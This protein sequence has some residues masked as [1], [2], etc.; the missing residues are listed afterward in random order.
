M[1]RTTGSVPGPVTITRALREFVA[2]EVAGGIVLVA[3]AVCGLAWVNGPWGSTYERVW[4]TTFSLSL[5]RWTL[6]L[7]L[8]EWV[9]EGLMALFF[10]VVALEIKRELVEGELRDPRRAALPVIGAVGGMVVPALLYLVISGGGDPARG[11]GIPMA[12]DIAF[13]LGVLALVGRGLPSTL[14]LF[15]LTLAIVDDIGAILVIALFYSGGIAVGWLTAAVGVYAVAALVRARGIVFT[16]IFVGF[17]LVLWLLVHASGLHATLAG[18]AMGLLAPARPTLD[19]PIVVSRAEQML[20]VFSPEAARSTSRL[21]QLAVSQLEWLL[22]GLHPWTTLVIVPIFALANSGVPLSA[23]SLS[24]ALSSRV[25]LA[26]LVGLVVGKTVGI[27]AASWLGCRLGVAT[28]P[29]GVRWPQLFGIAM[30]GGIGFTV[31]LFIT[32][33]AFTDPALVDEAKIGIVAASVAASVL[34]TVVLRAQRARGGGEA[35][36]HP[37]PSET[38]V[39]VET[40]PAEA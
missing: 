32:G 4:H 33:L 23:G 5:G 16:P 31:S 34:G 3:A 21:A 24:A 9:N 40:G 27:S 19:R 1:V 10:V 28:L 6:A 12:T 15:L 18:V 29:S 14:R 25:T 39:P 26:V 20:D 38:D 11:W 36:D 37:A 8:R 35:V 30:V 7:D 13:A 17:G 2:T 22:H